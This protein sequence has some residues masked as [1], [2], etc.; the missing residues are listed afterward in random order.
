MYSQAITEFGKP[1]QRV[2]SATPEPSG[3]EVVLKVTNCGVCHSD[4]HIPDG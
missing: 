2:E 1:L 4:V 3:T